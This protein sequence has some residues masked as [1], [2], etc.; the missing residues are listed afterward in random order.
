MP[1]LRLREWR[2]WSDGVVET[3][4]PSVEV[5]LGVVVRTPLASTLLGVVGLALLALL[6]LPRALMLLG[7]QLVLARLALGWLQALLLLHNRKSLRRRYLLG[8]AAGSDRA[9]L[10]P[11]DRRTEQGR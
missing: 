5:L 1:E 9:G 4:N 6:L 10:G 2:G 3:A 8:L 7:S 11:V